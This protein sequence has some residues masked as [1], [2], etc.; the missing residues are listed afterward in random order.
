MEAGFK[1]AYIIKEGHT[2]LD[3]GGGI[4]QVSTT[5]FRA[6]LDAGLNIIERQAHAYRVVY[7]EEDSKPGFD[8]TVFIPSPD[9][10]FINDTSNYVLIRSIYDGTNKSLVYEIYGTNDGRKIEISNYKQWGAQPAP[11]D[12]YNDDPTLPVGTVVQDEHKV[13]GLNTSFDWKV[14][15]ADGTVLHQKTYTSNFVP[16]AAVYRRGTK[17]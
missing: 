3:V 2:I 12:I 13:P 15:K 9:L 10:K 1:N 8:A 11:P 16:W 7:Y 17:I 4:C 14:T 6:M 5:L